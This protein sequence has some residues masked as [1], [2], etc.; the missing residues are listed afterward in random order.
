[1]FMK[2][3]CPEINIR[4]PYTIIVATHSYANF[5]IIQMLTHLYDILLDPIHSKLKVYDSC[6]RSI[7]NIQQYTLKV[8]GGYYLILRFIKKGYTHFNF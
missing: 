4:T 2:N 6:P 3:L 8:I 5:K 7:L 1:M